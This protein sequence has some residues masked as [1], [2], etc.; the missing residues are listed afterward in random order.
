MQNSISIGNWVLL[1]NGMYGKVVN[2]VNDCLMVEF[3]T[4]KS[5]I[6]PVRRDQIPGAHRAGS[7]RENGG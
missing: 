1:S 4:N 6:I 3:G 2:I 7:D 5:V